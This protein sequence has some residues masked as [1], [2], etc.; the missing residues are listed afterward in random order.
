[1]KLV[2]VDVGGTFTD[3]VLFDNESDET[4]IHKVPTTP[5]DP[6]RGVMN[7]VLELC[8]K[9]SIDA[10]TITHVYHGTTIATNAVL[11]YKGSRTGM[12]TTKGY[13]DIIHIGR[14]QRPMHYS[15]MQEIPLAASS[16]GAPRLPKSRR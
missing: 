8:R 14:H 9:L 3:V 1:M 13:R 7:G 16:A 10:S 5:E 2:G 15:I 6:S 11:E 12:I 4:V